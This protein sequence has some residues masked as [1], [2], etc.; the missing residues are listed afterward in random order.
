MSKKTKRQIR[1]EG[2]VVNAPP[3]AG[4][5]Q[6]QSTNNRPS[7]FSPDYTYIQQDLRRIGAIWGSFLV[8]FVILSFILR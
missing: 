8:I 2:A 4:T 7:D 3:P 5:Q 6:Q 1:K